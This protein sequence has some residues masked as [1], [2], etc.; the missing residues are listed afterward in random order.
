MSYLSAYEKTHK[1]PHGKRITYSE[2]YKTHDSAKPYRDRV[3]KAINRL[4]FKSGIWKVRT[5]RGLYALCDEAYDNPFDRVH[6]FVNDVRTLAGMPPMTED[7]FRE[8]MRY[9]WIFTETYDFAVEE[10]WLLCWGDW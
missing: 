5:E 7:T 3:M 9:R 6:K 8:G 10:M 2:W 4:R 1:D